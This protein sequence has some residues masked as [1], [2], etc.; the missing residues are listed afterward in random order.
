M[1]KFDVTYWTNIVIAVGL[2]IGGAIVVWVVG[3]G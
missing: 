3:A 2:K 1:D